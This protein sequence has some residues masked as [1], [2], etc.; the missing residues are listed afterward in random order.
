MKTQI[1]KPLSTFYLLIY[2]YLKLELNLINIKKS[3]N[4]LKKFEYN[5]YNKRL[6][7]FTSLKLEKGKTFAEDVKNGL[8]AKNKFLPPKYFYD[9]TGSLLFEK[10]CKTKE[11]YPTVTEKK[12]LIAKAAEISQKNMKINLITELGSGSSEKSEILINAFQNERTNLHYIPIDVSEILYESSLNLVIK[13]KKLSVSG[14]ISFYENGIKL[15]EFI[16]DSPKLMLFL[17]S[18]IGNFTKKESVKFLS[19]IRKFMNTDDRL[20]VG[21]D[22]IK[23][24]NIMNSAYNDKD[25]YTKKFNLNI[26]KRINRELQGN[27]PLSKFSHK[28]FYNSEKKR[29]EM[30]L[31]ANDNITVEIGD[32]KY[33]FDFKKGESIHTENSCKFSFEIIEDLADRSGL[34]ISDQYTDINNYFTITSLTLKT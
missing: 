24:E 10:I 11:Y 13:Y 4:I 17:G 9:N 30:Y 12:I 3:D 26:L 27:F 22:L 18:S 1:P 31:T 33:E 14:I 5:K 20:M 28:A 19:G 7:I 21:F 15:I 29:I 34:K 8:S 2:L 16:D 32:G 6:E 23:D 25:G